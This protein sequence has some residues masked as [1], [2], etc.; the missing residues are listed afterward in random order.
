MTAPAVGV[1]AS[2]VSVS[3]EIPTAVETVPAD[4]VT[5][6][7]ESVSTPWL[8]VA[9]TAPAETETACAV[10]VSVASPTLTVWGEPPAASTRDSRLRTCRPM[11]CRFVDA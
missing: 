9:V 11:K 5:A 8:S 6:N 4:A 10:S 3:D 7:E 2:A 1:T